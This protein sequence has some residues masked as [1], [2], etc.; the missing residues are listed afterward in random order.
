MKQEYTHCATIPTRCDWQS[1]MFHGGLYFSAHT[2][3][4]RVVNGEFEIYAEADATVRRFALNSHNIFMCTGDRVFMNHGQV[5]IGSLKRTADAIA[6]NDEIIAI[7]VKNEVEVWRVPHAYDATLFRRVGIFH[8]HTGPIRQLFIINHGRVVTLGEDNAVRVFDVRKHTSQVLL[9]RKGGLVGMSVTNDGHVC[10][11]ERK[12]SVIFFSIDQE[13]EIRNQ[14]HVQQCQLSIAKVEGTVISSCGS[15]EMV[16]VISESSDKANSFDASN[17]TNGFDASNNTINTFN[18]IT[19]PTAIDQEVI[20]PRKLIKLKEERCYFMTIFKEEKQVCCLRV[21]T[22]V[23]RIACSN[24]QVAMVSNTFVGLFD[25]ATA[26]FVFVVDLAQ[27]V[28]FDAWQGRVCV[29]GSDG[30]ARLHVGGRNISIF[31]DETAKGNP[32][33]VMLRSRLCIVVRV[34]GAVSVFNTNDGTC[35]RSFTIETRGQAA[36][37][38]ICSDYTHAVTDEDGRMLFM[39]NNTHITVVDL[40]NSRS[41]DQ[42]VIQKPVVALAHHRGLLFFIDLAGD[43]VRHSVYTGE[44]TVLHPERPAVGL[45]VRLGRVFLS[46]ATEVTCYDTDFNYQDSFSVALEGRHRQEVISRKKPVEFIGY[47]GLNIFCAGRCN[48]V[49]VF[50][51]DGSNNMSR[52][53]PTNNITIANNNTAGYN[54]ADT[55]F[56]ECCLNSNTT[57]DTP[58]ISSVPLLVAKVTA[59]NNKDWENYK[60]KLGHEKT[61]PFN[62]T[63]FIEVRKLICDDSF[64]YLL[65]REGVQVYSPH[66]SFYNPIEFH[67]DFTVDFVHSSLKARN[68]IAALIVSLHLS[69]YSLV[70]KVISDAENLHTMIAN[71][72]T[73][74][75]SAFLRQMYALHTSD[76]RLEKPLECIRWALFYHKVSFDSLDNALN[77]ELFGSD[78]DYAILRSTFYMLESII[79]CNTTSL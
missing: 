19:S 71:L 4:Y 26:K 68:Y 18:N 31:E 42:I 29:L 63:N 66:F 46:T 9:S 25:I 41:I 62:C 16:V 57:S 44:Q 72:P 23:V 76:S 49:K 53:N 20:K 13:N 50:R 30:R 73:Q 79:D 2:R 75:V 35:F 37:K 24:G 7:A 3:V 36:D 60:E 64:F 14:R 15:E 11:T 61:T 48:I 52:S 65:T 51:Y 40:Q 12:G 77:L 28:A 78:T 33:D 67:L 32:L 17:N 5:R 38:N 39:A 47:N 55:P 69:N 54:T 1:V 34:T 10:V 45:S 6:V 21:D 58:C 59:S 70:Y 27:I 56:D 22:R 74:Y 8:G 43:L